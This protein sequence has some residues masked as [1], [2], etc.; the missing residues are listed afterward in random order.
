MVMI[1][2][3]RSP[4]TSRAARGCSRQPVASSTADGRTVCTPRALVTTA[5]RAPGLGS[6]ALAGKG[7][8]TSARKLVTVDPGLTSTPARNAASVRARA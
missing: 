4:G 2:A 8:A 5:A 7:L 1:P 6:P 3:G